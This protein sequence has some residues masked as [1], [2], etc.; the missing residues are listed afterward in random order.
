MAAFLGS[1][2]IIATSID[3]GIALLPA[4]ELGT[5]SLLRDA[6]IQGLRRSGYRALSDL[7]CDV[8]GGVVSLSG[9]V[10]SFFMKQI[11]QTIILRMGTVERLANQLEVQSSYC[12]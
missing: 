12:E 6:V 1:P 7:K 2:T 5:D 4:S 11:A 10:P 9:V 3:S 8:T